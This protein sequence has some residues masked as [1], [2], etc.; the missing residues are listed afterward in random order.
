MLQ[1]FL[2]QDMSNTTEVKI[3]PLP[4]FSVE[5]DCMQRNSHFCYLQENY[6]KYSSYIA[7]IIG[8]S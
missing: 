8:A 2:I 5:V 1:M 6:T 3:H 7:E 4:F